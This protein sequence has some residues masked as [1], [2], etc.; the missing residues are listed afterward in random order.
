[1]VNQTSELEQTIKSEQ[2]ICVNKSVADSIQSGNLEPY[3]TKMIG[4]C[5][6]KLQG[7][8]QCGGKN[9]N[10]DAYISQN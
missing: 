6:Y 9:T 10:C 8:F 4:S 2:A 7:C 3:L 1:M 5:G